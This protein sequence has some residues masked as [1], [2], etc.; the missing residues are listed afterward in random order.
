MHTNIQNKEKEDFYWYWICNIPGI[1]NIKIKRL[2]EEFQSPYNIYGADEQ[3]IK[4]T[5]ILTAP[6]MEQ[7]K[8]SRKDD[9]IYKSFIKLYDKGIEFIHIGSE[10]YPKNLCQLYDAPIGLY[11][12][13]SLKQINAPTV[14]VV[15]ARGC[16]E[17]G[18]AA[19]YKLAGAFAQMGINVVSGMALGIDTAS[20]KGCL[21]AGGR[22]YAVFGCGVDIC[23]PRANI[24]LYMDIQRN[25]CLLSEYAVGTPPTAGRFPVRNRIISGI[26]D[27]VVVVEA[28][29]RSGSLITVDQ[30]LE[31]NKDVFVVP[32]RISD[33]LSEGC[34]YLISQ[35]AQ[36]I[37]E[38]ENIM[39]SSEIKRK[40]STFCGAEK[41]VPQ[42]KTKKI[43][44]ASEKDMVYS[45]LDLYPKNLDIII[46]ETGFDMA[47][48]NR[49]IIDMQLEGLVKEIS[50][51]CYV[52]NNL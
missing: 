11:C 9:N 48:V 42:E 14:A 47:V 43:K 37:L 32:G 25:G 6:D 52:R 5:G 26:A 49:C 33:P 21:D 1:G 20:H 13:G 16:S 38:P 7:L 27:A 39:Q 40:I 17:Y 45:C 28:R 24:Q 10:S 22:T 41:R 50:K 18:R 2:L 29:K 23:Y 51:N 35:G 8:S 34:N 4:Q 12:K 31:Q 46:E 15:G 36:V 3:H 30:A 19:A 44:L